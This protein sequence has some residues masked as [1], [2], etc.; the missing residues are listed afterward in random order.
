MKNQSLPVASLIAM[1]LGV[2]SPVNGSPVAIETPQG[3][4]IGE[5][6]AGGDVAVFRGI[7]YALPPVGQRRWK[8][9]EP[10]ADWSNPRLAAQFGP[11]CVQGVLP[12]TFTTPTGKQQTRLFWEPSVLSSEDCLY[13]NVYAPRPTKGA[14]KSP[15]MVWI[16]GGGF[17]G[18]S[19]SG[20]FYDGTG[21]ARKGVVVVTINYRLGI[22]GFFAHPELSSESTNGTSGNYGLGDQL[23]ALRWVQR[24]IA[25][26]GGDPNNVTIF[27][28]SAGSWAVSLLVA[29]QKSA[30][31]FH[32]AIGESGAYLYSMPHLKERAGGMISAEQAGQ[33]FATEAADGSIAALRAMPATGL[34]AK[35][36]LL[37]A[38]NAG[39]LAIVDGYF[40]DKA[41][42]DIFAEGSQR[43]VPVLVGFNSDEG[44]GLSDYF[45]VAPVPTSSGSYEAEVRARFGVLA[46]K[47]LQQY[48]ANDPTAAVFDA[49]RDSEFGWR[50]EEWAKATERAGQSAYLYYFTH[51][52]P[53]GDELRELPNGPGTRLLG[54][55]HAAEIPYVFDTF[56]LNKIPEAADSDAAIAALMSDYWVAFAKTGDP[57]GNGRPRWRPYGDRARNYMLF[58][59]T[60]EP[61][62]NLLPGSW[63]LHHEIDRRRAAADI[64]WDGGSAGLLGRTQP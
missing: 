60:A 57:N 6:V 17:V 14:A 53:M 58:A 42:R 2:S 27:G 61:S 3:P 43:K 35:A 34:Q 13:L 64:P 29:T 54:A 47:W 49:Y 16:H 48:P 59:Q 12:A 18:G 50:M 5:E 62:I 25:A 21:L 8:M 20:P 31:L 28:E 19:G 15:V 37:H 36:E 45:V 40:F 63:E 24:N 52:P 22:F 33:A 7:P 41:V 46:K 30:G 4:I 38:I 55:Y 44:S 10:A 11:Q 1:G 56:D 51:T 26:Y 39:H 32:K 23:E 9:A